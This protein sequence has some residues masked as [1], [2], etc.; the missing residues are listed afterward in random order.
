[1]Q[2]ECKK[3]AG[4]KNLFFNMDDYVEDDLEIKGEPMYNEEHPIDK[5]LLE[6]DVGTALVVRR[7]C[8]TPKASSEE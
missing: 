5:F 1:M 6:G 4:K 7:S 2:S 3:T 8:L